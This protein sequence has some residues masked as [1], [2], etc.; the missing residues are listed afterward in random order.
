MTLT[1]QN[2]G[3]NVFFLGQ[4]LHLTSL[5]GS[6]PTCYCSFA[7]AKGGMT[8]AKPSK[9][10]LW[11]KDF[12]NR[13]EHLCFSC[14]LIIACF[15]QS[16]LGKTYSLYSDKELKKVMWPG[17]YLWKSRPRKWNYERPKDFGLV[18]RLLSSCA[19]RKLVAYSLN[20]ESP[21]AASCQVLLYNR[22]LPVFH[23]LMKSTLH[24]SN[25]EI[26]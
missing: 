3:K 6:P 22:Q 10:S 20:H 12:P 14:I 9:D 21:I 16:A 7:L 23:W 1:A 5:E 18:F 15:R 11:M 26:L 17:K 8:R 13:M 19:L 25:Y 2:K 24:P 4:R